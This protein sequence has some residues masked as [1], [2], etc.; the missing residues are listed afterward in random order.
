M[1]YSEEGFD[2][3]DDFMG[4]AAEGL[5][6]AAPAPV[7]IEPNYDMPAIIIALM[8]EDWVFFQPG[9][10]AWNGT[11]HE[12]RGIQVNAERASLLVRFVNCF[13]AGFES[14]QEVVLYLNSFLNV[15]EQDQDLVVSRGLIAPG[16][17]KAL[18]EG[19]LTGMTLATLATCGAAFSVRLRADDEYVVLFDARLG[20]GIPAFFSLVARMLWDMR[21]M[22]GPSQGRPF[23]VTF[24]STRNLDA[25]EYLGQVQSPVAG[26]QRC[27]GTMRVTEPPAIPLPKGP[28]QQG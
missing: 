13:V 5:A 16:V 11:N 28:G 22:V 7:D 3:L 17:R 27:P 15:L 23:T 25:D 14:I 8:A 12:M 20:A 1:A 21:W 4:E 18:P 26:A 2:G 10:I 6:G 24:L 9:E 19:P